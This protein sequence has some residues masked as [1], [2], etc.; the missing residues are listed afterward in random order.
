MMKTRY[1]KKVYP[2]TAAQRLHFFTLA[3]CPKKQVLNIGTSL[4]IE[5][6]LDWEVLKKAI[7]EA[8][9]RCESMRIRFAKDK[10]GNV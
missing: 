3:H 7:Y 1:G 9:D 4:T 5:Q 10:A 2:I 6:D 8:Y